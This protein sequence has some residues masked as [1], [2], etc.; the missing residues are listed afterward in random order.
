MEKSHVNMCNHVITCQRTLRNIN[1][2]VN[3]N[4]LW[5]WLIWRSHFLILPLNCCVYQVFA[6]ISLPRGLFFG[7]QVSC[8]PGQFRLLAVIQES[9]FKWCDSQ[10]F[11]VAASLQNF[12]HD[13]SLSCCDCHHF[14]NDSSFSIFAVASVLIS[15]DLFSELLHNFR[16]TWNHS[17]E[18]QPFIHGQAFSLNRRHSNGNQGHPTILQL[19]LGLPRRNPPGSL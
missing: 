4:Q 1:W 12:I 19:L 10:R 14:V 8:L 18:Q 9:L 7:H 2:L 15:R 11:P 16:A 17:E 6:L 5:V 3:C 13:A